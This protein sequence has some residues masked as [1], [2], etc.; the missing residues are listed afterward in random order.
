MLAIQT[1]KSNDVLCG[2]DAT[3]GHHPGNVLLRQQIEEAMEPY[4]QATDRS[5][6]IAMIDGIIRIMRETYAAR[7]LRLDETNVQWEQVSEQSV[8]DKVSHALRF[9]ARRQKQ[10][11]STHKYN[12]KNKS[13]A[14]HKA[15]A[16]LHKPLL[17]RKSTTKAPPT[18]STVETGGEEL[19]AD[20][21]A[22]LDRIH[23]AQQRILA[24]MMNEHEDETE[25]GGSSTTSSMPVE[26]KD[27]GL[28][29]SNMSNAARDKLERQ[30]EQELATIEPI[31][32]EHI[33][34]IHQ[35]SGLSFA[36]VP[37]PTIDPVRAVSCDDMEIDLVTT[38][39]KTPTMDIQEQ[40]QHQQQ[41]DDTQPISVLSPQ[42]KQN[43]EH[44]PRGDSIQ[45][46]EQSFEQAWHGSR[47]TLG[48]RSDEHYH[49]VSYYPPVMRGNDATFSPPLPPLPPPPVYTHPHYPYGDTTALP[50]P[51]I[52]RTIS[53]N[54]SPL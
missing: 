34:S 23:T 29:V 21:R 5:D 8:R 15:R 6:K 17:N 24:R 2:Q 46:I 11:K 47:A 49:P 44:S 27:P 40:Q 37:E 36:G 10:A 35:Y 39:C 48:L 42:K 25:Q 19:D 28:A 13:K 3:Y 31:P 43:L 30:M 45:S 52:P 33:K 32:L 18:A 20:A 54:A 26:E 4:I 50:P 53:F 12:P 9:A 38:E 1:P 41:D 14:P 22:Y 51:S 7:F 16:L